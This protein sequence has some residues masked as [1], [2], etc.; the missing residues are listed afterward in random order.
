MTLIHL[1]N[2]FKRFFSET[3]CSLLF[4]SVIEN[5]GNLMKDDI[6][7]NLD[8]ANGFCLYLNSTAWTYIMYEVYYN[9]WT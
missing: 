8:T 1:Q 5:P 4:R 7:D 6:A 9:G 2:Y 3:K